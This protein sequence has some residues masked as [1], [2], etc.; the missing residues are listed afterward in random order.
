[1]KYKTETQ[2]QTATDKTLLAVVAFWQHAI[3]K[4]EN[5]TKQKTRVFLIVTLVCKSVFKTRY[6]MH[7]QSEKDHECSA[8]EHDFKLHPHNI[9]YSLIRNMREMQMYS[10]ICRHHRQ[11]TLIS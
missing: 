8:D 10:K 9:L 6:L 5:K 11:I 2:T 3:I 1:M 7:F 4:D